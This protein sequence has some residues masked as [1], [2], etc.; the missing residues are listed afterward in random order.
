ME[1]SVQSVIQELDRH[2]ER[3]E[4]F[5]RSLTAE[6]LLR[7]V[8]GSDWLVRDFIAHL[9]TIDAPVTEM[10]R[11]YQRPARPGQASASPPPG[12]EQR[13]AWDVDRW[14]QRRVEDRRERTIDDL[15]AEAAETRAACRQALADFTAEQVEQTMHFGGDSKRPASQVRLLDYL[16]GWCKHDPMHAVDMVRALPEHDTPAIRAWFDDPVI[17]GYQQAMNRPVT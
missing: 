2:R 3:F 9:A 6:Q 1:P 17:Q 14:N 5:C 8:P 13:P 12:G 10:F 7:P 4:A 15:L 16:R 11:G